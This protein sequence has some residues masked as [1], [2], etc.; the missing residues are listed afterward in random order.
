MSSKLFKQLGLSNKAK[1][2]RGNPFNTLEEETFNTLEEGASWKRKKH[3]GKGRSIPEEEETSRRRKKHPGRGRSIK[4][5]KR[6]SIKCSFNLIPVKF[7]LTVVDDIQWTC[8]A[9]QITK[10][11]FIFALLDNNIS[12][13]IVRVT[14]FVS[15]FSFEFYGIPSL[16]GMCLDEIPRRSL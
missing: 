4:Y 2:V 16:N 12:S 7:T 11:F 9:S 5:P 8:E 13:F 6:G 15:S 14:I 1:V 10:A 3:P